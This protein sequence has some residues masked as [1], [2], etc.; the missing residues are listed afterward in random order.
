MTRE[1]QVAALRFAFAR[2]TRAIGRQPGEYGASVQSYAAF[3][4]GQ[5]RRMVQGRPPT[6]MT[7][8]EAVA[9]ADSLERGEF[10][11]ELAAMFGYT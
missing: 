3:V 8:E 2:T 9:F 4:A 7:I 5:I 6:Q 10:D 11:S 1:A